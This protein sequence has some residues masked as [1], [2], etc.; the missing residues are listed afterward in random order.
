MFEDA[1]VSLKWQWFTDLDEREFDNNFVNGSV[2]TGLYL[3]KIDITA[4]QNSTT[5]E[6]ILENEQKSNTFECR[7]LAIRAAA[8]RQINRA[9]RRK[10]DEI[11]KRNRE[12]DKCDI[13]V[14]AIDKAARRSKERVDSIMAHARVAKIESLTQL[15][16]VDS[17]SFIEKLQSAYGKIN[18]LQELMVVKA[19]SNSIEISKAISYMSELRTLHESFCERARLF[20]RD[21]AEILNSFDLMEE[22]DDPIQPLLKDLSEQLTR[23]ETQINLWYL[24]VFDGKSSGFA[25]KRIL[26]SQMGIQQRLKLKWQ[27]MKPTSKRQRLA[28]FKKKM[29]EKY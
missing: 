14:L 29:A 22:G 3:T 6:T 4:A 23:L 10:L 2:A 13:N 9:F 28:L 12:A 15:S 25:I 11:K 8:G 26:D 1:D 24:H 20:A 5:Q 17:V 21:Q 16:Q 18:Y 27:R 19:F 7:Q